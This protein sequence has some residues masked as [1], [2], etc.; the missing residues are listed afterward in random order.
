MARQLLIIWPDRDASA[1]L[2]TALAEADVCDGI[3]ILDAYPSKKEIPEI[4]GPHA[5]DVAAVVVGLSDDPAGTATLES[6]TAAVPEAVVM[7]AAKTL[8]AQLV[9]AALRAGASEFLAAP[10]DQTELRRSLKRVADAGRAAG[11][12]V[13]FLPAR[14]NDGASTLAMHTADTVSRKLGKPALLL[15]CDVDCGSTSFRMGLTPPFCLVD[16]VSKSDLIDDVW[17]QLVSRWGGAEVLP[18]PDVDGALSQ[19]DQLQIA[20][21]AESAARTYPFVMLDLPPALSEAMEVLL[22]SAATVC[23]TC[24][25]DL[26]SLHLARRKIRRLAEIGVPD[27]SVRVVVNRVSRGQA[28]RA[29]DVEKIIGR[30]VFATILEDPAAAAPA[31][32]EGVPIDSNTALGQALESFAH[33]LIGLET[34][35]GE[36]SAPRRW[37]RLFSLS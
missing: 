34:E 22:L 17:P 24:S 5:R 27:D 30:P 7:A 25:P 20:T 16:A 35:A 18:G 23:L 1:E 9:R 15:D 6:L 37:S 12:A 32:L 2:Q 31:S 10:F 36:D 4:C 26:T 21:V 28:V 33:D 3:R 19:E 14:G 11:T 13:C 29:Q 8:D